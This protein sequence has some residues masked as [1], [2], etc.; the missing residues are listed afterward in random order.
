MHR[1]TDPQGAYIKRVCLR[2]R[3]PSLFEAPH[4]A[5]TFGV[6]SWCSGWYVA[7]EMS[8]CQSRRHITL[9]TWPSTILAMPIV[10]CGN[11]PFNQV[12]SEAKQS[13][14]GM[15]VCY[16]EQ[17]KSIIDGN[18]QQMAKKFLYHFKVFLVE[19]YGSI[20]WSSLSTPPPPNVFVVFKDNI[21][22]WNCISISISLQSLYNTAIV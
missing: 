9:S 3:C 1:A 6:L 16:L 17:N 20:I 10:V 4:T 19:M 22:F 11:Y 12:R 2:M 8:V 21:W 7:R 5:F 15:G 13:W 14:L 18:I